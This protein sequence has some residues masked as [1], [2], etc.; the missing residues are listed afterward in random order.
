M[1]ADTFGVKLDM[2]TGYDLTGAT[3]IAIEVADHRGTVRSLPANVAGLPTAG[4]IR[5]VTQPTDFPQGVYRLQAVVEFADRRLR[6]EP[7]ALTVEA[8]G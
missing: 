8:L 4:T 1:F 7:V 2:L 6:S 5:R 3:S